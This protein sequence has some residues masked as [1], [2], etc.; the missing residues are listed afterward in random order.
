[1]RTRFLSPLP[2]TAAATAA[3]ALLSSA[4]AAAKT[5]APA[6][7]RQK[8][9]PATPQSP[10]LP[11]P[12]PRP[13][14]RAVW[15]ATV[16]NID[17]PSRPGL[18]TDQQK[19]EMIALL[20]RAK[21]LNLNAVVFQVRPACDALYASPYEP[22]SEYL[23][24]QQGKAP[25]PLYDPLAFAVEEAH[26]RGLELHAWFNPY[27]ARTANDPNP[28]APNHISVTRPDLAKPYGSLIW[29]DP[30][31]P[32]VQDETV[33]VILDVVKRYDVDGVHMDD[34][35]YPYPDVDQNKNVLPFP[36][37]PSWNR[38]VASGG[39]LNR[40]DW[41]R[42]NV[43]T[44]IRRLHDGIH[45]EKPWVKFGVS[46]FGIWRPGYPEQIQGFDSYAQLYADS[47]RWLW[48]GW[49]DYLAPQ[50]YWKIE[51]TPQS[52]P[53]L[54]SWWTRQNPLGRNLWPGLYT[55]RAAPGE[56]GGAAAWPG[57]EIVYQVRATRGISGATGNVHFSAK[58]LLSPDDRGGLG[59]LLKST[60]YTEPA[61]VPASPWLTGETPPPAPTGL[62][63]RPAAGE[64]APTL[65]WKA[66][67]ARNSGSSAAAPWEWIV[68]AHTGKTWS[69]A[70]ILTRD[71]TTLPVPPGA[72]A[73][74][75]SAIGR[76]G[77]ISFATVLPLPP[78]A[79]HQAR[80]NSSTAAHRRRPHN[81]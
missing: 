66:A 27:R 33:K 74:A 67:S 25:D 5:A 53:V 59:R 34:Y 26:K 22:W 19:A 14:F 12:A 44:L 58:S 65:S 32:E 64:E 3:A 15:I 69:T 78:A 13:E 29:L 50:L 56:D 75:V 72:D 16:G 43:N 10:L 49:V 24:G 2:A 11:P 70:A 68:Q 62:M 63:L 21:Q 39:K 81:T 71:Q 36:D 37:D 6:P 54:L 77:S 18:T 52:Y 48:E 31:E 55:G 9:A 57:E 41:R 76:T 20:D 30:G 45:A 7:S 1:M 23:T 42:E 61:P 28:A 38:Y 80:S 46:P 4:G 35:F 60:V 17:W 8:P 73:V 40:D 79:S 47:R 51:Q